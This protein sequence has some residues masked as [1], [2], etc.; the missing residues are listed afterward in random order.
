MSDLIKI[1]VVKLVAIACAS[2]DLHSSS[3]FSPPDRT[4]RAIKAHRKIQKT[5]GDGYD[6]EVAVSIDIEEAT[7]ES[8]RA[9]LRLRVGGRIDGIIANENSPVVEEIKTVLTDLDTID[10][11]DNPMYW[12]QARCYAYMYAREHD[13][14]QITI[15]IT[16]AQLDTLQIR[17]FDRTE[18]REEL[19]LFFTEA[20]QRYLRLARMAQDWKVIRNSSIAGLSF[21]F[22]HFRP[23]Q[24][25]FAAEVYRTVKAGRHLF[26]QAPT[27]TGKTIATLFP[28]IKA[29]GEDAA[30][31]IFYLT[32]KGITATAARD[33]LELMR[34]KGLRIRSVCLTA[35]DKICFLPVRSCD[36]DDCPYCKGYYDRLGDALMNA[37]EKQNLDREEIEGIA[38]AH[39]V[40]P[41]ELSLD[42]ALWC[43]CII[44]DFNYAF[45]PSVYLRRFFDEENDAY[46]FL[47]DEAHNL[48]DRAREM[49]SAECIS[50]RY[51][52]LKKNIRRGMPEIKRALT[53]ILSLLGEIGAAMEDR[54]FQTEQQPSPELLR[55]LA[56]FATAAQKRLARN[57]SHPARDDLL[58]LYFDTLYF[59]RIEECYDKRY[60]TT[61]TRYKKSVT[62]KLFCLDPSFLLKN[63]LKRAKATVFFSATLSPLGYFRDIL[64]G[65]ADARLIRI[66]SPFPPENLRVLIGSSVSTYYKDR[67]ATAS[68]IARM[69]F[70]AINEKKGNYLV[71]FPSYAY[72]SIVE[73]HLNEHSPDIHLVS[74]SQEMDES[75]RAAFLDN[76]NEENEHTLVGLAV[77][78]GVFGEG[79]DLVGDKLVGVAVVGVGLPQ[80]NEER[81]LIKDYF[82]KTGR[83]G[84]D[85]A[86][87]YPG[88]NKVLQA[89][90]RVIRTE[91][92]KG[93]LLLIDKRFVR[94]PYCSLLPPEWDIGYVQESSGISEALDGFWDSDEPASI[95]PR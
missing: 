79:I 2:G 68:Q 58:E 76:F 75:R 32:A 38:Q 94:H 89:A 5:Y 82:Q 21:P 48:V 20:T 63:A 15:R 23:R 1:S 69:I 47:I 3:L 31:K 8:G 91:K 65:N 93:M 9:P 4:V 7:P 64:G 46:V 39:C 10:Q 16:Y 44:C 22:G 92:D 60:R 36:P 17:S 51:A 45:D 78:G 95:R 6:A 30:E 84:F 74:Q 86:Y 34:R 11:R 29:M 27:G 56:A 80:I 61:L 35:K 85:F 55:R 40:C 59:L 26:A 70:T 13:L 33:S 19:E 25:E 28:S 54:H 43:D 72:L 24:R 87:I 67:K 57:E 90:G 81:E 73:Q 77:M 88:I 12:A 41:F 50:S 83:S 53:R 71:F 18:T 66:G 37:F 49:F 14:P 52:A 42:V 62:V